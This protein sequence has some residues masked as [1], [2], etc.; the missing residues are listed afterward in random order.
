L[1]E[2]TAPDGDLSMANNKIENLK[3]GVK[4]SDAVARD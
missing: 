3:N 4:A 2:V 1:N